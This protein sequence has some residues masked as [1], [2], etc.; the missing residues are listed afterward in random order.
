VFG[1]L[2]PSQLYCWSDLLANTKSY[3]TSQNGSEKD[4]VPARLRSSIFLK[5]ASR[6]CFTP[7]TASELNEGLNLLIGVGAI[8][9]TEGNSADEQRART[10]FAGG[11]DSA[12]PALVRRAAP[13]G[14][15]QRV[16]D[17]FGNRSKRSSIPH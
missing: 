10:S 12:I 8:Y 15:N 7:K 2:A 4:I 16:L 17:L 9:V 1:A 6:A 3:S 14:N 11:G 5:L 13:E